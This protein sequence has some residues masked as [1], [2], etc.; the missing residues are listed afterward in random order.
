MS[1]EKAKIGEAIYDLISVE[2]YYAN[3]S[4][5]GK[6][7]AVRGPGGYV[8]PIRN[9]TDNRPGYYPSGGLDFYK[10][11]L[12]SESEMYSEQNVINFHDAT[13]LKEIIQTQQK[14]NSAERSIL[15][16][17]DNLFVPEI[18][19]NDTPE[20]AAVKQA[21]IDK[22]IDLD[23]YEARIGPNY[24]NDKRLLKK[25]SMTFGKM[26]GLLNALDIKATLT[27]EDAGPNVPNPIGRTIV[28]D[29]TGNGK[30]ELEETD[31]SEE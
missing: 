12:F 29:I 16:T 10:Q 7:A 4:L 22:H 27:L 19:D 1:L 23:K 15:T 6:Y 30:E 21:I 24:N 11:P 2:E 31:G 8:Y 9:K 17:V 28:A 25:S 26:R 5:Y 18:G 3:P 20:M 14:L 13:T